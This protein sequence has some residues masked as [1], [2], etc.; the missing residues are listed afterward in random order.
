[1]ADDDSGMSAGPFS[2]LSVSALENHVKWLSFAGKRYAAIQV[3]TLDDNLT[4]AMIFCR[5]LLG[6]NNH[7]ELELRN[8]TTKPERVYAHD[9]IVMISRTEYAIMRTGVSAS[10]F[11]L[12]PNL[13]LS[14]PEGRLSR[15]A[16]A[17]VKDT[18]EHGGSNGICVECYQVY[19]CP[20]VVWATKDR[21]VLATWDPV[22]DEPEEGVEDE[23]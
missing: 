18:D 13:A 22:D 10:L 21:D 8:G 7:Q 17:H 20:T 11:E 6:Y 19:P 15:I 5:G 12:M 16:Q 4:P 14:T 2:M 23:A 1:M 9:W 3:P